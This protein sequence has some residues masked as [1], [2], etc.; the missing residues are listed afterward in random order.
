MTT[1]RQAARALSGS[2]IVSLRKD[3]FHAATLETSGTL[4]E[5]TR[6]WQTTPTGGSPRGGSSAK[7][8][9]EAAARRARARVSVR[10]MLAL[11]YGSWSAR[12]GVG[13]AGQV[14]LVGEGQRLG[15]DAVPQAGGR[16]A[17]VEDVAEV[18][19]AAVAEDL[20]ADHAV[21]AVLVRADVRVGHWPEEAGPARTRV[22]LGVRREQ[23]QPAADA[24][25][26][27]PA[28][29]VQQ[30][31]AEGPLGA[32]AAGDLELLGSQL[33]PPLGVGLDDLGDVH[34]ADQLSL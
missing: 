14:G 7:T 10:D 20:G 24:G 1:V 30:R 3:R 6:T 12:R 5:S 19:V 26:D 17:V 11:L 29:V 13:E 31:S 32:L 34:G 8:G 23:R 2:V 15:V 16:G 33:L 25:V 28:F 21:T 22:E 9:A 4:S 18:G 27:S